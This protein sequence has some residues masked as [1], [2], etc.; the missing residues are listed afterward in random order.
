[1]RYIPDEAVFKC[2]CSIW[3]EEAVFQFRDT[4]DNT[5]LEDIEDVPY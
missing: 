3:D 1:M 4:F 2:Y 5:V